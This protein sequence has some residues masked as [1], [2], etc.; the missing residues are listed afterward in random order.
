MMK[1][2]FLSL[3]AL[4]LTALLAFAQNE[5]LDQFVNRYKNYDQFTFAFLSKELFDVTSRSNQIDQKDLQQLHQMIKNFGSLRILAADSITNGTALYQEAQRLVPTAD[6]EALLTVRD[7]QETVRIWVKETD[8]LVTDLILLVGAPEEFV[9]IC[10]TGQLELSQIKDLSNPLKPQNAGQL[11]K[12]AQQTAIDFSI[13]PN[14]SRGELIL[15]YQD[16]EDAP[17]ILTLID[18]NGRRLSTLNLS[19]QPNESIKLDHLPDG[20]YW[21][22]VQTLK[23]KVGLKQVQLLK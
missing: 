9:L 2:F 19:G 20:L 14:P 16:A 18:V 8:N 7:G 1:K 21:I 3:S 6:M 23:G 13:G 10:F 15:T 17:A 11:A 12:L 22:Q 4:L 5:A